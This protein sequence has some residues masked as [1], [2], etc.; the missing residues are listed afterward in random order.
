VGQAVTL[1][2]AAAANAKD[3]TIKADRAETSEGI[4]RRKKD[5][6]MKQA[7]RKDWIGFDG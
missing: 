5:M 6:D 4:L 2:S 1:P 7:I 3:I